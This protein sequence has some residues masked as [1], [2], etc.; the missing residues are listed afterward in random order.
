MTAH[1]NRTIFPSMANRNPRKRILNP[2]LSSADNVSQEAADLKRQKLQKGAIAAT[3]SK[4]HQASASVQDSD[5]DVPSVGQPKNLRAEGDSS[6]D[7]DDDVE[8][9]DGEASMPASSV[10]NASE[11]E[12]CA[13]DIDVI[14]EDSHKAALSIFI[15]LSSAYSM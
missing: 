15:C 13:S 5:D 1:Q 2:K 12:D 7:S 9:L 3:T 14:E 6:D 8:M 10:I 11:D 4:K